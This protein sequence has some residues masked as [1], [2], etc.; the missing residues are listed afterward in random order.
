MQFITQSVILHWVSYLAPDEHILLF[1]GNT[2]L[3]IG[4]SW[5][6]LYSQ[7]LSQR[8][9]DQSLKKHGQ[10]LVV[11]KDDRRKP[12]EW[13]FYEIMIHCGCPSLSMDTYHE[14]FISDK[15]VWLK[16][17]VPMTHRNDHV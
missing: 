8:K 1:C 17:M 11:L 15:W 14:P 5:I 16:M 2:S 6:A 7:E 3:P 9:F 10:R 13:I 12:P 4:L